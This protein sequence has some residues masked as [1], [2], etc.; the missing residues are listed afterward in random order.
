MKISQRQLFELD[1]MRRAKVSVR[2]MARR[3]GVHRNSVQ[4]YL[5]AIRS[6]EKLAGLA[7]A[8][9]ITEG[10]LTPT[11]ADERGGAT[12]EHTVSSPAS[13]KPSGSAT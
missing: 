13:V 8:T 3:L 9:G 10:H 2:E 11:H 7:P 12:E 5:N 6:D 1:S 4:N